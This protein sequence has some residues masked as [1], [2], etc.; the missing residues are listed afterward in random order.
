VKKFVFRYPVQ[1]SAAWAFV[2]LILCATPG[3]FIPTVDWLSM[4]SFDKLVHAGIFFVLGVLLLVSSL[5]RSMRIQSAIALLFTGACYGF[6]MEVGQARY[7]SGRSMEF[8][9]ALANTIGV[10]SSL[11][12]Y[13]K[14]KLAWEAMPI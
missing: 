13:K 10:F 3:R 2:I 7:F 6:L 14:L 8:F 12:L 11:L 9:D 5:T 4:L 1:L